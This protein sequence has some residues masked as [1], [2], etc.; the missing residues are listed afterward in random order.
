MKKIIY[1]KVNKEC[2]TIALTAPSSGL[3]QPYSIK[4]FELIKE[5]HDSKGIRIIEGKC[6]RENE[7]YVS[8]SSRDRATDFMDLYL[9]PEVD[10]IKPPWGG[11]LL[12]DILEHIDFPKLLENPKWVQ[13]YSD[14][15]TLLFAIT[16]RLGIATVHGP[17]FMDSIEGQ[18]RLTSETSHYLSL[19][20]G[21][22]F[23]QRSSENWQMNFVNFS[24]KHDATFNLTEKTKVK[25][26]GG[27]SCEISGRLIGGCLDT[28]CHLVG[29]P[30][31]DLPNFIRDYAS[32]EGAIL[33]FEN[34]E[35]DPLEIMRCL[36]SFRY[37]GWFDNV[38]GVVF[39]RNSGPE[40]EGFSYIY[41]LQQFFKD[42]TF[43]VII[44]ADIGH[45]PPQFTLINGAYAKIIVKNL[46]C[47]LE[48]KLF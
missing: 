37:A 34:C 28:I 39:G 46:A 36:T 43:P 42:E 16:T 33:Y 29:T 4:R 6:L 8:G 3:G 23:T 26:L 25:T 10:L 9:R 24:E 48:Q 20:A 31:G 40:K 13:G 32:N 12:I 18:D 14:L 11:E 35:Q 2:H 38:N 7:Y 27:D 45:K 44:D 17:N 19:K 21:D 47:T 41:C 30:Y 15:S 5:Q 1:P 22:S